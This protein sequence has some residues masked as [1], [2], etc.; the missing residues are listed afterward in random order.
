MRSRARE[1]P[2]FG[3]LLSLCEGAAISVGAKNAA[4]SALMA[5]Q[6]G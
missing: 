1:V 4:S 2:H 3:E 6:C 5:A